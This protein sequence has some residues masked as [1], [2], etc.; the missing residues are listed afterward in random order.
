M[1]GIALPKPLILLLFRRN[2]PLSLQQ[3]KETK[4]L[5]CRGFILPV[6]VPQALHSCGQELPLCYRDLS[7]LGTVQILQ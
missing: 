1:A 5:F 3:E 6:L 2:L 7:A 4:G